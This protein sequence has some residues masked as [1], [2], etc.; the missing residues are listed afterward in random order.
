MT[1][2]EL[3]ELKRLAKYFWRQAKLLEKDINNRSEVDDLIEFS[4]R[5]AKADVYRHASTLLSVKLEILKRN[6]RKRK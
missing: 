6:R 1:E 4:K 3:N 2:K 5:R